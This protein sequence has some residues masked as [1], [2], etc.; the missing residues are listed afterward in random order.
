MKRKRGKGPAFQERRDST[1]REHKEAFLCLSYLQVQDNHLVRLNVVGS[2][3]L[4]V[5]ENL[6]R[7]DQAL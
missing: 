3:S 7:E 5:F 2:N 1:L 6:A 4:I